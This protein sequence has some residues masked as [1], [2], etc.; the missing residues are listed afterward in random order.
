MFKYLLKKLVKKYAKDIVEAFLGCLRK[1]ST[2]TTTNLDYD[3][4]LSVENN[5][6][7]IAKLLS[8]YLKKILK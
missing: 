5:K 7:Q 2:E 1:I 8:K 3:C 4:F 6:K